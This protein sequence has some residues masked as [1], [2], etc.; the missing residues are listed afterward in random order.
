MT[1]GTDLK[2]NATKKSETFLSQIVA[3]TILL[4]VGLLVVTSFLA[5]IDAE[6]VTAQQHPHHRLL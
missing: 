3:A 2:N 1:W 5:A 6:A 4:V